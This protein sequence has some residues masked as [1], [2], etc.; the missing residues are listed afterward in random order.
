MKK[1]WKD[2]KLIRY[3]EVIPISNEEYKI[4]DT[5]KVPI[6]HTNG[7]RKGLIVIGRILQIKRKSNNV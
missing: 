4:F 6:F 7:Q 5:I 2:G 1:V 3:E